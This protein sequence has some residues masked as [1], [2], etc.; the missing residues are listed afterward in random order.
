M[1]VVVVVVAVVVVVVV[2]VETAIYRC[3]FFSVTVFLVF[4]APGAL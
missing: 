3:S 4:S 1:V 2:V